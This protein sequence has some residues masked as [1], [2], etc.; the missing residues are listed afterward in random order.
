[1]FGKDTRTPVS[2]IALAM[3]VIVVLALATLQ[4]V[5]PAADTVLTGP[6]P[7]A[8]V[9]GAPAGWRGGQIA[10]SAGAPQAVAGATNGVQVGY[11]SKHVVSRPLR[12]FKPQK[13][14]GQRPHEAE[15]RSE[16]IPLVGHT[17]M[18]DPVMQRAH[19]SHAVSIAAGTVA[20]VNFAGI[21]SDGSG[22][23]CAPPDTD[24]AVGP[25]QYVQMVNTAIQV[26]DKSGNSLAG[27]VPINVL[28]TGAGNQCEYNNDGDPVALYDSIANRWLVSQFTASP[29]YYECIAISETEDAANQPFWAYSFPISVT[30][31]PDY[32]KFGVW[33]DGYYMSV[34]QFTNGQQYAGP[35]PYV[36]NRAQMLLGQTASFQTFPPLGP[37]AAPL[38][39]AD[40]NGTRLPPAGSPNYFVT[41]AGNNM[42]I[43]KYHVDWNTPA[44]STFTNSANI[45]VAPW[46][47]LCPT[48]VKCIPQPNTTQKVDGLGDR[49][50]FRLAYRNFGDHESMVINQS[51]DVGGGHAGVRWYEVRNPG[52]SA[53]IYQQG[54]YAPDSDN[55]WAASVAMDAAGDIAAGYSVSSSSTNPSVRYASR[56]PSDPLGTLSN[57]THLVDGGGSQTAPYRWG[58]YSALTIDPTDDCT[59]WYTQ[60]YYITTADYGWSTQIGSFKVPNCRPYTPLSVGVYIPL[61]KR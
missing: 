50:M 11:S 46:T 51:V 15:D 14:Q 56:T 45:P 44:N 1:M 47:E 4:A 30:T 52:G 17:D 19:R 3:S 36:F 25:T 27:P 53:S 22:C 29:P 37:D 59:F 40:F 33:P 39:P 5:K 18:A 42:G 12:E 41:P 60:E 20:G 9:G 55:R 31:F 6:G 34:N 13:A 10:S 2:R 21:D 54:T 7:L 16:K 43:Y 35:A 57:E 58:D 26:F 49:Y 48:T 32:P 28:W 8:P 38:M 24:G 23:G 61:V